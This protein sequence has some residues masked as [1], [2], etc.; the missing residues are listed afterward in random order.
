MR[1]LGTA[2]MLILAL[3]CA[4]LVPA[5][6][7]SSPLLSGYGGPGTGNQAI[8]GSALLNAPPGNGGGPSSGSTGTQTGS[9]ASA[10]G[11]GSPAGAKAP[12]SGSSRGGSSTAR[13]STDH[14]SAGGSSAY[15][16]SSGSAL[17]RT[18]VAGSPALGLSGGD[19]LY[20]ILVLGALAVTAVLTRRL[21]CPAR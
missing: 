3:T 7:A 10:T 18:E 14:A 5:A 17:A 8:L 4:G 13:R 2:T 19:L 9:G 12:G 16:P 15:S 20:I 11:S 6:F 1:R 21:A